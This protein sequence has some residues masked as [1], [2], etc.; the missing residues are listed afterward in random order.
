M[1][2]H[3][4]E[5]H[6]RTIRINIFHVSAL[7]L[8]ATLLTAC[9]SWLP[10]AHHIEIQQGN[11]IK[12]EDR[13]ALKTGMSKREVQ[14]ILGK[15]VLRDPF[16]PDRWDYIYTM[17][18]DDKPNATSRLTLHFENDQLV[19]IDDADFRPEE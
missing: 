17:K 1:V 16:H 7:L 8:L 4:I 15:A 19:T 13:D 5:T 9:T 11:V 12:Q 14:D 3:Q 6:M 18:S 2:S 10:D